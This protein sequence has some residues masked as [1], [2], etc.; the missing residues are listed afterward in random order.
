MPRKSRR[1]RRARGVQTAPRPPAPVGV[2]EPEQ[3]IAAPVRQAPVR[4]PVQSGPD[5][6]QQLRHLPSDIRRIFLVAGV[7]LVVLVAVY[8]LVR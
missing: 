4:K 2:K 7:C 3:P 5:I 1:N 6:N 8:F